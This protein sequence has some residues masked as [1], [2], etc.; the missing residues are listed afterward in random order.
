MVGE[1]DA[2]TGLSASVDPGE[3]A[4]DGAGEEKPQR[5]EASLDVRGKEPLQKGSTG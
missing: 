2:N 4:V 5:G 3:A 1:L